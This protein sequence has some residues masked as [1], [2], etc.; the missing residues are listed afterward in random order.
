MFKKNFFKLSV[1]LKDP[2]VWKMR[3]LLVSIKLYTKRG[4]NY[5]VER[6][7]IK[8]IITLLDAYCVPDT[9]L[10]RLPVFIYLL[11]ESSR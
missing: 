5:G 8:I 6:I 11:L 10:I 7:M 9:V 1:N 2:K 4:S 3:K